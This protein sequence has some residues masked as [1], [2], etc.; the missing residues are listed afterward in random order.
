MVQL[1]IVLMISG[2][3]V[4]SACGNIMRVLG[5]CQQSYIQKLQFRYFCLVFTKILIAYF[6]DEATGKVK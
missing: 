4:T 1:I 6:D 2:T 5:L 3:W